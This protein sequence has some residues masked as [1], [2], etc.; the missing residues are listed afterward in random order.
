MTKRMPK[1]VPYWT[2]LDEYTLNR[3]AILG[4][5][6]RAILSGKLI[7]GKHVEQFENDFAFYNECKYAIGVNSGTDALS[8]AL[9]GMGI[10]KNDEV[11]TVANT[12]IPT[13]SAI[14]AIGAIPV[15]VEI[16]A[17]TLLMDAKRIE[18][19]ITS[20]TKCILPVHLYGNVC[21]MDAIMH[22]A[23][24]HNLLVLEDCA[25][26]TGALY[27]NK[28]VGSIGHVSAFSFYPT[29]IIGAYGD[30]GM[31]L[32]NDKTI[33]DKIRRLRMYGTN[34]DYYSTISGYNSRLDEI[35]AALL[36]WKLNRIENYIKAREA[37]SQR[38]TSKLSGTSLQFLTVSKSNRPVWHLYVVRHE[39]RDK[40]IETCAKAGVQ[41]AVHYRH[42]IYLQEGYRYLGYKEGALPITES[43][44]NSVISLPIY[45][46]LNVRD[47]N[48][49]INVLQKN[50]NV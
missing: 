48:H 25:Q 42:P 45:P 32:T 37:I 19:K 21:E 27:K 22:I 4:V 26:S 35:Q 6:D 5:M 18:E 36:L 46:E 3:K 1:T 17:D 9:L 10:G 41:L 24:K 16:E 43:A 28:K 20:K 13:V 11:L 29:K 40:V 30:G 47:Q 7:L 33:G 50:L 12:A 15:F 34:G 23:K 14:V 49:I 8:L 2:Y 39:N 31:I 44:C 38:Y